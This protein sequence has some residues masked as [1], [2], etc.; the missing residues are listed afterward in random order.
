MNA[1]NSGGSIAM[2]GEGL[3]LARLALL[4]LQATVVLSRT[5]FE[6]LTDVDFAGTAYYTVRNLSLYECQ[7]W[8]REEPDCQAASFRFQGYATAAVNEVR[9]V[10]GMPSFYRSR[11][12]RRVIDAQGARAPANGLRR[13]D[14]RS[15]P[16]NLCNKRKY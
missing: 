9:A 11:L 3:R 7:G 5:A 6:K 13:S 12:R 4:L 15:D 14:D 1:N 8:C 2:K 10:F 16:T